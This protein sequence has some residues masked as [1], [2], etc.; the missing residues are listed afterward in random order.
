M[1]PGHSEGNGQIGRLVQT[2]KATLSKAQDAGQS[3]TEAILT[4]RA[5]PAEDGI[6][7]ARLSN[8][9]LL[10]TK[11]P[12]SERL[13]TSEP[14]PVWTTRRR[15]LAERAVW[16]RAEPCETTLDIPYT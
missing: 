5:T 3:I 15:T 7:P 10:R 2:I 13:L 4:L 9:R 16:S 12:V 11:L 1:S 14:G 6:S 8:G